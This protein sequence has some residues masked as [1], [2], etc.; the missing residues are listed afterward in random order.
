VYIDD[1]SVAGGS[2]ADSMVLN[3]QFLANRIQ[4]IADLLTGFRIRMIEGQGYY[5]SHPVV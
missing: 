5:F 2:K 3:G 1:L 4:L